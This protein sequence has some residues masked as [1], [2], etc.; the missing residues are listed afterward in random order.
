MRIPKNLPQFKKYP[1]F[2]VTSGEYDARFYVALDGR[3][4][5]KEEI[6]MPPRKEAREKQ[7]FIG[8]K[9]GRYGL[10]AVSHRGA[11]IEDLKKKFQ[12][13]FHGVLRGLLAAYRRNRVKEIYVFSQKYVAARVFKAVGKE[14]RKKIRMEFFQE[15]TKINPLFMIKKFW[16]TEQEA[17]KFKTPLKTDTKKI[18]AKQKIRKA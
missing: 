5:L 4:E 16:E 1:A 2:F 11:Y 17:V 9:G 3:L 12:K 6:K 8:I 7:A 18:L 10:A 15:D 14:E 13:K